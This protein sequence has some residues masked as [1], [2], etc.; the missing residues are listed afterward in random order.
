[1][2]A[3]KHRMNADFETENAK[4]TMKNADLDAEYHKNM[5]T[6]AGNIQATQVVLGERKNVLSQVIEAKKGKVAT[7][8]LADEALRCVTGGIGRS[9]AF[10]IRSKKFEVAH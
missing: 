1:M 7:R 8:R 6:A 5:S 10:L 2:R 4:L 9:K 3:V